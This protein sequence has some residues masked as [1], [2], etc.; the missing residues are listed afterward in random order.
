MQKNLNVD[1][2]VCTPNAIAGFGFK[3]SSDQ[4][5][6][7]DL[8]AAGTPN[9]KPDIDVNIVL[10]VK[11]GYGYFIYNPISVDILNLVTVTINIQAD[12]IKII[13]KFLFDNFKKKLSIESFIIP[14]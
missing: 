12:E 10:I 1:D 11:N 7:V 6:L 3:I 2:I 4:L 9:Y 13:E 5:S 14:I 8:S